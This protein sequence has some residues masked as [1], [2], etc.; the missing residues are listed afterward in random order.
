M[1]R[2]IIGKIFVL[3]RGLTI[4]LRLDQILVNYSLAF[5]LIFKQ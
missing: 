1:N 3:I 2:G 5:R 4:F